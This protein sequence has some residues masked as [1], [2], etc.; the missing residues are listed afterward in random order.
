MKN[1]K[2]KATLSITG[3]LLLLLALCF[4]GVMVFHS[5]YYELV[6]VSGNS[7]YPT[8]NGSEEEKSGSVVDFGIVDN[9]QSAINHIKRFDI[10]STYYPNTDGYAKDY[11]A[12]GSLKATATKKIKR[13]IALPNETFKI[14]NGLLSVKENDEFKIIPNTFEIETTNAKDTATPITLKENEYWVLGDNR[15]NSTDCGSA[16]INR[17]IE[18]KNIAGVLVAIEGTAKLKLKRMVCANCGKTYDKGT[19]CSNCGGSLLPDYE[20]VNKQYHWPKYF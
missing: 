5:Y 8:L 12:D 1:K 13:V 4:T 18:K 17:P 6:Y 9:H 19:N 3:Y 7:M 20:L 2:L 11:K 10:V 15:A 16:I 14:E